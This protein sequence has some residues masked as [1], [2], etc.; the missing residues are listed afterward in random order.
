ML[1][2]KQALT[3]G[4]RSL[5]GK[6][7]PPKTPNPRHRTDGNAHSV[8]VPSRR[9]EEPSGRG[10]HQQTRRSPTKWLLGAPQERRT[11]TVST[12]GTKKPFLRRQGRPA[13]QLLLPPG[14]PVRPTA[15]SPHSPRPAAP[16]R[17]QHRAHSSPPPPH[18]PPPPGPQRGAGG[19]RKGKSSPHTSGPAVEERISTQ[20]NDCGS[21]NSRRRRCE[22]SGGGGGARQALRMLRGRGRCRPGRRNRRGRGL[23]G[24]ARG[25]GRQRQCCAE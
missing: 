4:T 20:K 5:N 2:G 9:L 22:G 13:P 10:S 6:E 12:S 25:G 15:V 23:R 11:H 16:C 17:A 14:P 18:T 1:T 19:R 3:Q 8:R 24:F 21:H 7:Q